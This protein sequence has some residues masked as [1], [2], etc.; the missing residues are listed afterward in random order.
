LVR[1]LFYIYVIILI[2]KSNDK[3]VEKYYDQSHHLILN[4]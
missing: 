4:I 1:T 2:N 3:V